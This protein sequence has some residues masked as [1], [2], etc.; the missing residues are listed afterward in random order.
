MTDKKHEIPEE[1]ELETGEVIVEK[2]G[3]DWDAEARENGWKA[4]DE[5]H[6][7]PEGFR[8]AETFV[9]RGEVINGYIRRDRDH[10]RERADRAEADRDARIGRLEGQYIVAMKRQVEQHETA[11]KSISVDQRKAAEEGNLEEFDALVAKRDAMVPPPEI[12]QVRA[13]P[14]DD[15]VK[16]WAKDNQWFYTDPEMRALATATAGRLAQGGA[17]AS[18][19]VAAAEKEVR[20]RFPEKFEQPKAAVETA[21]GTPSRGKP[22][23]KGVAQ[24]PKEARDAFEKFVRMG[25]YKKDD[26]PEYAGS[27]WEQG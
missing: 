27:Y 15:A 6:G 5:W 19:Q 25:I 18:V 16:E 13:S 7:D 23:P 14:N 11:L 26:L 2:P 21:G 24:L 4:K 17:D 9:K 10:R 1:H 22:K 8:D 20:R 3:R 12:P